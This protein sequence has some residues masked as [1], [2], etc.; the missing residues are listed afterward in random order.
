MLTYEATLLSNSRIRLAG[1]VEC[2]LPLDR[3]RTVRRLY[4]TR[5]IN[6]V[7]SGK[8]KARPEFPSGEADLLLGRFVNGLI[9]GVSDKPSGRGDLKH[10]QNLDESWVLAFRKPIPG[11]R[12]FGRFAAPKVFVGLHL[13]PRED[14]GDQVQY[15]EQ[16]R[17]MI[18]KWEK[19]FPGTEPFSSDNIDDY[20]GPMWT[21]R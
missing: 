4:V 14:A 5:E 10:L 1:L 17:K 12:L 13:V 7:I 21:Q 11:W 16:A 3:P 15:A 18:Q 6:N 2:D 19:R 9:L 20:L 8:A